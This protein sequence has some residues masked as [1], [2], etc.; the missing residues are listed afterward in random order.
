MQFLL[1]VCIEDQEGSE[2]KFKI[3][4]F[5]IFTKTPSLPNLLTC[6]SQAEV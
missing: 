1:K 2:N 4:Y 6:N 5:I 3:Q